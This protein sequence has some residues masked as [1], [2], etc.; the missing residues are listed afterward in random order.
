MRGLCC[1]TPCPYTTD[2]KHPAPQPVVGSPPH[3][4]TVKAAPTVLV[5]DVLCEAVLLEQLM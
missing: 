5:V 1:H 3:T 4:L 2:H